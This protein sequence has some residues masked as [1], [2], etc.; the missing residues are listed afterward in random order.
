MTAFVVIAM[1]EELTEQSL[2]SR[3][4]EL[5]TAITYLENSLSK[6][7]GNAYQLAI[8]TYALQLGQSSQVG[9]F[10]AKLESLQTED[11]Q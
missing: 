9:T 3:V 6:V 7:E 1:L 4:A 8:I 10:L 11:G 2:T 5:S